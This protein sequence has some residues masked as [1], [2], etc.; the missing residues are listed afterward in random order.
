MLKTAATYATFLIAVSVIYYISFWWAFDIDVLP[1]FE[2]QDFILGVAFPLRY[3]GT[4]FL[5]LV[6]F[7]S[8]LSAFMPS[9]KLASLNA[10]SS[11]EITGVK[12]ELEEIKNGERLPSEEELVELYNKIDLMEIRARKAKEKF[13]LIDKIATTIFTILGIASIAWF[14]KWPYDKMASGS[15]AFLVT[16]AAYKIISYNNDLPR[17]LLGLGD[18]NKTWI[19]SVDYVLILMLIFLPISAISTG[20]SES[21]A[22]LQ[23]KRFRYILTKDLPSTELTNPKK[24]LV[25]LG[26]INEKFVLTDS[27][28]TENIILDKEKIPILRVHSFDYSDSILVK[29]FKNILVKPK[30]SP[31]TVSIQDTTAGNDKEH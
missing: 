20:Y 4:Y 23:G 19:W 29:R 11:N 24:Y 25:Y 18:E 10:P 5:C 13:K 16:Q 1:F 15:V 30:S 12:S 22:I 14:I 3:S 9:G 31:A 6:I 17:N 8:L 2:A 7:S 27:A 28:N 21:Q 26:A